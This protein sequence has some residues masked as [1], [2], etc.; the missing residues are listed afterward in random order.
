[1]GITLKL[2]CITSDN[3]TANDTAMVSISQLL[4]DRGIHWDAVKHRTRCLGHMLNLAAQAFIAAPDIEAVNHALAHSQPDEALN[5]E[6]GFAREGPLQTLRQFFQWSK[7]SLARYRN[8]K[9]DQH[10]FDRLA[11]LI[12]NST[13]W[14]S[15]YAMIQRALRTRNTVDNIMGQKDCPFSFQSDDWTMLEQVYAFLKP[16]HEA[17]VQTE[18]D[19]VTLD[20]VLFV[21]D[22]IRCHL[23]ET[24]MDYR[25]KDIHFHAAVTTCWHA[26]NKW[27]EATDNT[28]HYAAAVLLHPGC[29]QAYMKNFWPRKWQSV[30]VANARKLWLEEYKR[31]AVEANSEII[32]PTTSLDKFKAQVAALS[33][34]KDDEFDQFIK[35]R[36]S[37]SVEDPLAWW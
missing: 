19:H 4:R 29:R 23:S 6:N 5:E 21:M 31:C 30:A 15:W 16:F 32:K 2:G 3:A 11:P 1:M 18:G 24:E 20:K 35:E 12:S 9:F 22:M 25:G 28:P 26:F 14:N 10:N 34:S 8:F 37:T 27:Y 13:R 17:T 33:T 36:S 7:D